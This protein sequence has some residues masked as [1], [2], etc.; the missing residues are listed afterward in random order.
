[1]FF[2]EFKVKVETGLNSKLST[3]FIK[4]ANEY[5]SEILVI[6]DEMQ[7]NAKSL[8]GIMSLEI[9]KD[10]K[11]KISANGNDERDAVYSLVDL[12]SVET[13]EEN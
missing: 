10:T 8:L 11:I 4:K 5:E 9:A 13:A 3:F 12:L 1:M 7:A 2:K 6:K